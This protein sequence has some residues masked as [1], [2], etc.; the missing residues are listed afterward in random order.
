M[1]KIGL[2]IIVAGIVLISFLVINNSHSIKYPS[3]Q[4]EGMSKA[5][6][7]KEYL[8]YRRLSRA[9]EK[10]NIPFDG[11]IKAKQHIDNMPK[12]KKRK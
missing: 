10:G 1:K 11:I 3:E 5:T 12:I 4:K 6:F 8:K 9:D 7:M 2:I